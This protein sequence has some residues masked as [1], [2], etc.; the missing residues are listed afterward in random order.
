MKEPAMQALYLVGYRSTGKTKL[1]WSYE[2]VAT[3]RRRA[4]NLDSFELIAILDAAG[5][6][7]ETVRPAVLESSST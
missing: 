2:T 4:R 6:I 7:V 1:G 3:A 5:N